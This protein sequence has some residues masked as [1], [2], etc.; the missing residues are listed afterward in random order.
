MTGLK[1]SIDNMSDN[2]IGTGI[3]EI[4]DTVKT[5]M[6]VI[7]IDVAAGKEKIQEIGTTEKEDILALLQ[8]LIAT[9]IGVGIISGVLYMT[10]TVSTGITEKGITI[11]GIVALLEAQTLVNVLGADNAIHIGGF[12][13]FLS[14]CLD[15]DMA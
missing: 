11:I 12:G 6:S 8:D 5:L 7:T 14:W 13:W 9:D 10:D 3:K 15:V 4:T 1:D 2:I